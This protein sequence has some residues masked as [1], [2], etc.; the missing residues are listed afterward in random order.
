MIEQ[1]IYCYNRLYKKGY[2]VIIDGMVL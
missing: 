2:V 1:G